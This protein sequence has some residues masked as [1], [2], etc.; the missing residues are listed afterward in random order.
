MDHLKRLMQRFPVLI[1]MEGELMRAY[2]LLE[3][4]YSQGGKLLLCGNGGSAADCDHIVG[5]LMKGFYKNVRLAVPKERDWE[6]WETVCRKRFLQ[7]R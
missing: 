1:D 6:I 3:D 4:A 5:E 7:S 2:D